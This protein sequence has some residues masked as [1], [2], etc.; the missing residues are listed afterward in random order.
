MKRH[1]TMTYSMSDMRSFQQSNLLHLNSLKNQTKSLTLEDNPSTL[2]KKRLIKKQQLL[3]NLSPL[4]SV[5]NNINIHNNDRSQDTLVK[6]DHVKVNN[7]NNYTYDISTN[8]SIPK[9]K[10]SMTSSFYNRIR[11]S[12]QA[13]SILQQEKLKL[14][15]QKT[16][17]TNI[18]KD[19]TSPLVVLVP[20]NAQPTILLAER[21]IAWRSIIKS[22]IL[23]LTEVASVQDEIV[24]QQL[25]L[26]HIVKF[27][28]ASNDNFTFPLL[29]SEDKIVD[30]KLFAPI[31]AGS[32]QEVPEILKQYHKTMAVNASKTSKQLLEEVIP[33]LQSLRNDLLIK[34]KEIKSLQTDFN[35]SCDKEVQSTRQLLQT[36][37]NSIKSIPTCSKPLKNKDRNKQ[38]IQKDPYLTKLILDKQIKR[39][40]KEENLLHEAFINIQDSGSRLESVV[41]MEI[42]N[43]LTIFVKLLGEQSQIIFDTLI[44]KIDDG[45]LNMDPQFEWNNFI[46][47]NPNFITS[48]IPMRHFKDIKYKS[49][50]NP[51]IIPIRS[52][53]I[54]RRSSILKTYTTSF[55]VLTANYLHEFK[56]CDVKHF[57]N[58]TL[59]IPLEKCKIK[60]IPMNKIEPKLVITEVQSGV[61]TKNHI[62][63]FKFDS[64]KDAT[65]WFNDIKH[66]ISSKSIDE[67]IQFIQEK[68]NQNNIE[69]IMSHST[70]E[71]SILR[72]EDNTLAAT[73]E[74]KGSQTYVHEKYVSSDNTIPRVLINSSNFTTEV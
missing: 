59:S 46:K 38:T 73:F 65:L 54:K 57:P 72:D 74:L 58:P 41:Y 10:N 26:A 63:T 53:Y 3:Q 61:L 8:A 14:N 31:G 24:R 25:R 29:A 71:S 4:E 60:N 34:I 12:L 11:N 2:F 22:L 19:I 6:S 17:Q 64:I 7:E 37:D 55:Y 23:Y 62:W 40:L 48:D 32:I 45:F 1:D 44:T 67:K 70:T 51:L 39:Q 18:N 36:F 68:E 9:K 28:F 27:P 69:Q 13:A 50:D 15:L 56:S 42:Q 33:R 16:N 49:Q 47:G 66:I 30:G 52:G 5:E 21:F 20:T 43:A 35:N